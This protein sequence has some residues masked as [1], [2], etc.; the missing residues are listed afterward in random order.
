MVE[1]AVLLGALSSQERVVLDQEQRWLGRV[2]ASLAAASTARGQ[3]E[4]QARLRPAALEVVRALRDEAASASEDD[5]PALLHELSVRQTL[6]SRPEAAALPDAESPYIAHLTLREGGEEKH[7]FLGQHTHLDSVA[8]VRVV[9]WRV[10]PVARIFY[11]YREG[12]EYEVEYPGRIAEGCVVARRIVVIERGA[13]RQVVGDGFVLS[14][15]ADGVWRSRARSSYALGGGDAGHAVQTDA[16][17]PALRAPTVTALLDAAQFAAISAPPEQALLVQG[18]AG[19]G[20]TT[21]ALHRLA[22][23]TAVDPERY[24]LER[25]QVIVPEE[26]LA[27]LSRRL[28]APLGVGK[29]THVSTLDDWAL[30]L[31]QQAFATRLPRL[32][33]ETPALVT[34]LKRHPA[35]YRAL[36]A[37]FTRQK[38]NGKSA[39]LKRVRRQLAELLSDRAFL[40]GVVRAAQG[41]LS[42]ASI[43]ATVRHTLL[44]LADSVEKQ[45][46]AVTDRSRLRTVDGQG[47]AEGTPE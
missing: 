8:G 32:C 2:R 18:S 38:A 28:L 1:E 35:L 46:A 13:L 22:R 45:L 25:A 4:A 34:S 15:S 30:G 24:P 26:G 44:Q 11:G 3:A 43:E 47:L 42:E 40:G 21:V 12:D 33:P 20:K 17:H 5:L 36:R 27:R 10:A 14:E 37:H 39:S 19:S 29:K 16:T 31:A 41:S 7:Y 9:D 23:I 6:L